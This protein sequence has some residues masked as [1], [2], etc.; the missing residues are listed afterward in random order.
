MFKSFYNFYNKFNVA[1]LWTLR[2]FIHI[3]SLRPV[4][5]QVWYGIKFGQFLF[6]I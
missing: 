4:P 1:L 5:V 3:I 2:F 6:D